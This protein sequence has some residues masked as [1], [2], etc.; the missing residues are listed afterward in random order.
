[1]NSLLRRIEA[2]ERSRTNPACT[3]VSG[4]EVAAVKAALRRKLGLPAKTDDIVPAPIWRKALEQARKSV[5]QK[6]LSFL[7][8]HLGVA[9]K[10]SPTV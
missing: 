6:V 3:M 2:I 5:H 10:P 4:A 9:V 1:M 7:E 8:R